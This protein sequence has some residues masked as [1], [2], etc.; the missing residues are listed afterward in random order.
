MKKKKKK[1]KMP[2]LTDPDTQ[3][4]PWGGLTI[5]SALLMKPAPLGFLL[6][7]SCLLYMLLLCPLWKEN[8]D[9]GLG[10][11]L[12]VALNYRLFHST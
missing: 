11:L 2:I 12:G 10:Q 4:L 3:P 6:V 1:R 9:M 8:K 5:L 7:F